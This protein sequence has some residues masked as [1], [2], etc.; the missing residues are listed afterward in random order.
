MSRPVRLGYSRPLGC[1]GILNSAVFETA[2]RKHLLVGVEPPQP[3]LPRGITVVQRSLKASGLRA[4][5][6]EA[7]IFLPQGNRA[8]IAIGAPAHVP[9]WTRSIDLAMG[10]GQPGM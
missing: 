7:A 2:V 10:R 9:L 6:S 8:D 4:N 3:L 5:R 1:G